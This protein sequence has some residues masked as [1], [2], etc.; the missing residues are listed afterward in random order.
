MVSNL[1]QIENFR[2][3]PEKSNLWAENLE[4]LSVSDYDD[5]VL[6]LS[7]KPSTGADARKYIA[8]SH[9]WRY[10]VKADTTPDGRYR[11]YTAPR[12]PP[13]PCKIRDEVLDRIIAYA[14]YFE[15]PK[16]WIDTECIR[17]DETANSQVAMDSMDLVYS[18]SSHPLGVLGT[19][20][21]TQEEVNL[22]QDLLF[23]TFTENADLKG[24]PRLA[25]DVDESRFIN[26][27]KVL[28]RLSSD[29]WWHRAWIFQEEYRSSINMLL[30]IRHNPSLKKG[31]DFGRMYGEIC[32]S[33]V[34][35]RT[36]A[37]LFLLAYENKGRPQWKGLCKILRQTFGKYNILH[38]FCDMAQD[39][40]MS[41]RIFADIG[42]RGITEPFDL[43]PIA[44]NTCDYRYHLQSKQ[45]ANENHSLSFSVLALFLLNGE[46]IRNGPSSARI[47][48]QMNV[49]DYLEH[50]SFR[51]FRP[52][53]ADKQL[54]FLK[55]ARFADVRFSERGICTAGHLWEICGTIDTSRRRRIRTQEP[56][57][58]QGRLTPFQHRCLHWLIGVL[59]D[60]HWL[61]KAL[62][63]RLLRFVARV[64]DPENQTA[65]NSLM[66]IMA[67]EVVEAIRSR[68]RLYIARLVG[69][70]EA[71]AV[72]VNVGDDTTNIFTSWHS[73][74]LSYDRVQDFYVSIAVKVYEHYNNPVL[75]TLQWVNG[76]A[77]FKQSAKVPVVFAWPLSWMNN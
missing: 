4:C 21:E 12:T 57:Y 9:A 55:K 25:E 70:S 20:L 69:S 66:L 50:I 74:N 10:S 30:L 23:G 15:V 11:T 33:S 39:K 68:K 7:R 47:P 77:F 56:Q 51:S 48:Q 18:C 1:Q 63:S 64:Q 31:H 26:L 43:L 24:H 76:L 58:D 22:L 19:I 37:T 59:Q 73:R 29:Q 42:R 54:S 27:L 52:P 44:A 16:F 17:Q 14:R 6:E 36:Q 60:E 2:V 61:Y 49:F 34:Q 28:G 65:A 45:L 53:V 32:I 71:T 3:H 8:V 67:E 40:A 72:F 13:R 41:S 38:R 46:I 35:L 62:A 5:S 75:R